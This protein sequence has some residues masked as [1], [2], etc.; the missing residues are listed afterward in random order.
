MQLIG[1]VRVAVMKAYVKRRGQ[2][3]L[4]EGTEITLLQRRVDC[5]GEARRLREDVLREANKSHTPVVT[6]CA[7]R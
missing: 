6:L 1:K 5:C 2:D 4:E 3:A 7:S